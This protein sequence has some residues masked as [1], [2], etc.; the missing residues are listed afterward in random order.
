MKKLF[1]AISTMLFAA[2][3][4]KYPTVTPDEFE[5]AIAE[6]DVQLVDV[7][8]PEEYEQGHIVGAM[9]IDWKSDAFADEAGQMLDKSKTVAVYCR[10]GRR[11][12]EAGDKL[13]KMGYKHIVELQGGLEAWK[14]AGKTVQAEVYE[15]D[16]FRTSNGMS[17][18]LHAL[19]HAS[20]WM[21]AGDKQIFV[22]PVSHLGNR[23]IDYTTMPTADFILITHEHHDHLDKEAIHNL[24]HELYTQVIANQASVDILGKGIV[25]ANGDKRT[26]TDKITIEAVPAYNTTDGHRQFHPKGRDNGYILNI[27]GLRI[28]I[29]G[30]TEDIPEM[31]DVKDIDIAFLPCN[32]PY[33][34][35]PEQLIEAA[36]IIQPKVLFPYHYSQTD[37]SGIAAQLPDIDVRIRH[38]E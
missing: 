26:L 12:H 6:P 27:D 23:S 29:A 14:A 7:R 35:T 10:A 13:Y 37:V 22:D 5:Q 19:V 17:V 32:Q 11:S 31:A 15:C 25:M 21:E 34:M 36:R 20:I 33:T 16:E 30:D 18:K 8:T 2:C 38:Y 1:F 3:A 9:N 4:P 28:Y 24:S